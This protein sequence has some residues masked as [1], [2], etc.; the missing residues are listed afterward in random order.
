ML[1]VSFAERFTDESVIYLLK[2]RESSDGYTCGGTFLLKHRSAFIL[3]KAHL[4]D[5]LR[6]ENTVR[7]AENY[8]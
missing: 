5:K 6:Q 4:E 8:S 3:R 1:N 7:I 2:V